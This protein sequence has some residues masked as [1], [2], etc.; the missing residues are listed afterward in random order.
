M[1]GNEPNQILFP[2]PRQPKLSAR[3][4]AS[5]PRWS[6]DGNEGKR[7]NEPN[8]ILF[9]SP[10]QPKLS[11]RSP[12]VCC[13]GATWETQGDGDT[14]R[15]HFSSFPRLPVNPNFRG[16]ARKFAARGQRGRR[17]KTEI[18][19]DSIFLRS[20]ASRHPNF[21]RGVM[22]VC[23]AGV[24]TETKGDEK[25]NQTKSVPSPPHPSKQKAGS[26]GSI[27]HS[28]PSLRTD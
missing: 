3:S 12:E 1:K 21:R 25:T 23:R 5:L 22:R 10:R 13:A 4:D 14:N 26:D 9:P 24:T 8:Q 15:F 20:P 2:P 11:G 6:N 18:R 7:K 16:E 17:K 27:R 19:T 28:P